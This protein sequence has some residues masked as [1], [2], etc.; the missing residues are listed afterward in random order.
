MG[1]DMSKEVSKGIFQRNDQHRGIY[2]DTQASWLRHQLMVHE[3]FSR[4]CKL[5]SM[6]TQK[7]EAIGQDVI[8]DVVDVCHRN[9]GR[10]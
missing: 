1:N 8:A 9:W 10:L 2:S 5:A 4:W 6:H 7:C 3:S